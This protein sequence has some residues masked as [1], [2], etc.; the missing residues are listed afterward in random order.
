MV[1]EAAEAKGFAWPAGDIAAP[2]QAWATPRE[3]AM[4]FTSTFRNWGAHC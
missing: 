3:C 2:V 4:L 1:Q